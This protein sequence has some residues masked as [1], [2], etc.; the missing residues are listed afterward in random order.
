[1]SELLFHILDYMT[2]LPA[3]VMCVLPVLDH[4]KIMPRV[5]L[6]VM[7]AA[8]VV[9]AV[10]LGIIRELLAVNA[11]APLFVFLVPAATLYFMA[12]DVKKTKL[13]FIFIS[14]MAVFS[15]GGLATHIVKAMTDS[16]SEFAIEL[17]AKWL[18]SM[19]FLL[20]EIVFLKQLRSAFLQKAPCFVLF[21]HMHPAFRQ[22][23]IITGLRAQAK[24]MS[25]NQESALF[26][27]KKAALPPCKTAF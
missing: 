15:F 19:L 22:Q 18:I 9:S 7:S 3:A 23:H 14:T 26:A 17:S 20:G 8:I 11:N 2:I 16:G 25:K 1:M 24:R 4:S 13:W 12:F 21:V 10:L 6:P 5:L 27:R